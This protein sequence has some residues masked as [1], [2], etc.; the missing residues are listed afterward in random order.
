MCT[1]MRRR[2]RRTIKQLKFRKVIRQMKKLSRRKDSR[3]S[4]RISISPRLT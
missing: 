3:S 2:L 1:N 4:L